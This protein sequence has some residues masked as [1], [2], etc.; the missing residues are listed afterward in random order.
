MVRKKGRA[1]QIGDVM[2]MASVAYL[3][4]KHGRGPAQT[5]ML[6]LARPVT[7]QGYSDSDVTW[8]ICVATGKAE[9]GRVSS[10]HYHHHDS[11]AE[12]QWAVRIRGILS[13]SLSV[14]AN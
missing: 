5:L 13:A 8:H 10:D 1:E 9:G 4:G 7:A 6:R 2:A 14:F 11:D 12:E 3:L